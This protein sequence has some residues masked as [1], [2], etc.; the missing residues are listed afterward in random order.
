MAIVV[1]TEERLAEKLAKAVA[2]LIEECRELT[3]EQCET[4]TTGFIDWLKQEL[5]DIKY[6][7]ECQR[8]LTLN[9]WWYQCLLNL[10]ESG[11]IERLGFTVP[12]D[13]AP[14]SAYTFDL[15]LVGTKYSC[16]C[17]VLWIVSD[18]GGYAK[19]TNIVNLEPVDIKSRRWLNRYALPSVPMPST[20][21]QFRYVRFPKRRVTI[22]FSNSH[23][24]ETAHCVFYADYLQMEFN[25]ALKYMENVYAVMVDE[26]NK[27]IG[28]R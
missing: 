16:V 7:I 8:L 20:L 27:I 17:P 2:E 22:T 9:E 1:T 6:L 3:P 28:V 4:E 15:S 23:P 13:V 12:A 18:L 10:W 25:Y 21:T 5:E 14:G 26:L 11:S 19:C 24:T